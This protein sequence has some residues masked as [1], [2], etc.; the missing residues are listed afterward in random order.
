VNA[1]K[2]T[3]RGT[4]KVTWEPDPSDPGWRWSLS[5]QDPGLQSGASDPGDSGEGG[6]RGL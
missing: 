1:L 6:P 2:S 4:V 5:V 3:E